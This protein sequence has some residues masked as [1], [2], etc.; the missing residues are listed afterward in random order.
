MTLTG[1]YKIDKDQTSC[2]HTTGPL[3]PCFLDTSLLLKEDS[4]R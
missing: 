2:G 1:K 3:L 4:I